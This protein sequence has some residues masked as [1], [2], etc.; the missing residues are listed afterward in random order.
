MIKA[1]EFL[2][3]FRQTPDD[4]KL[5]EKYGISSRQLAH[6]YYAL[7]EKELLTEF[8]YSQRERK[9]PELEEHLSPQLS[10]STAVSLVETP[11]VAATESLLNAG[12]SLDPNLAKAVFDAIEDKNRKLGNSTEQDEATT[13]LCPKCSS[14]KDSSSPQE[15]LRCG[16]VYAKVRPPHKR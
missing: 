12:Y 2:A 4:F 15:C 8:E 14:L 11:S 16:T 5:M 6:L 10:V 13:D 1:K 9:A 7:I 3:S